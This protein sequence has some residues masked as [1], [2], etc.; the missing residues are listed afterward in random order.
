MVYKGV[1][2]GFNFAEFGISFDR[3]DHGSSLRNS[4]RREFEKKKLK[5]EEILPE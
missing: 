3:V 1:E 4:T 5:L 2:N